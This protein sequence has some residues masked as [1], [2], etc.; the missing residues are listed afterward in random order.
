MFVICLS[1]PVEC[2]QAGVKQTRPISRDGQTH[3][4]RLDPSASSHVSTHDNAD[5]WSFKVELFPTRISPLLPYA[6]E[7]TGLIDIYIIQSCNPPRSRLRI[8]TY[9]PRIL[10]DRGVR[11]LCDNFF[12]RSNKRKKKKIIFRALP[13]NLGF[14]RAC[15]AI[16]KHARAISVCHCCRSW[17]LND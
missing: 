5:N 12:P 17:L 4:E 2:N 7:R 10:L 16:Q 11:I 1:F 15:V 13:R 3:R 6:E 8:Y 9:I 14:D